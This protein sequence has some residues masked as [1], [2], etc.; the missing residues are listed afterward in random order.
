M[1][2]RC[3]LTLLVLGFLPYEHI[4]GNKLFAFEGGKASGNQREDVEAYSL[5]NYVCVPRIS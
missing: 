1:P 2:E 5:K 3:A 4:T